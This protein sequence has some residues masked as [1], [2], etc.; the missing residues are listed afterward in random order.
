MWCNWRLV[1]LLVALMALWAVGARAQSKP[2]PE[3]GSDRLFQDEG[4]RLE[5]SNKVWQRNDTC[6][7]DSFRKFPDFTAEAALQRDAYMRDCL[8]KNHLP[9]RNDVARPLDPGS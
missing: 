4:S 2:A 6:G 1:G 8:R 3:K 7:K 9:P 5:R